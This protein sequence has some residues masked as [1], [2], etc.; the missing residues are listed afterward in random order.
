MNEPVLH[1][2]FASVPVATATVTGASERGVEL[3]S[4]ELG[5]VLARLALAS[6]D[7]TPR[8]GDQVLLVVDGAGQ[9]YVVGVLRALRPAAPQAMAGIEV[10]RDGE[11]MRLT[12]PHGDLELHA[13]HG[14]VRLHGS[15]GVEL[16]SDRDVTIEA[17]RSAA[18][19]CVDRDGTLRSGARFEGSTAELRAGVLAT[20][21]AHLHTV[22]EEVTLIAARMDAHVE[23]LRQRASELE[24]E[25]GELVEKARTAYREVEELAQT[26][27]GRLR[28]VAR[29]TLHALAQRAKMKAEAVFAID[30]E[31][32]HLG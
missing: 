26:R 27:A 25:A 5:E 32:I 10:E 29:T 24:I 16:A 13:A 23:R 30:G 7:Y 9:A 15:E 28:F 17:G 22:A 20:R 11:R 14:R 19:G 31:S 3:R 1:S 8:A 21:A 12:I 6:G 4:P 18:I 2:P